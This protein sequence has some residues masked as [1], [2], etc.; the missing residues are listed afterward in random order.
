MVIAQSSNDMKR[1]RG[2]ATPEKKFWIVPIHGLTSFSHRILV[3]FL[4]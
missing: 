2:H 3:R 1:V 4:D